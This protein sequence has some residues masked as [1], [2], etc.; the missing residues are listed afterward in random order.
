MYPEVVDTR[1]VLDQHGDGGLPINITEFGWPTQGLN[2]TGF[3]EVS[4]AQRAQYVAQFT[5]A[6]A[7][8][9]C[10]VV[11]IEPHTWVTAEQS[12]FSPE[13]WFGFVHP[14]LS[15]SAT[16]TAYS[17]TIG[18]LAPLATPTPYSTS[19]CSQQLGVA[20]G[21]TTQPAPSSPPPL[22]P[23]PPIPLLHLLL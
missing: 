7:R 19:T 5:K 3:T 23:L 4:D 13:D 17:S 11:R 2:S 16:E 14:N 20:A 10:G 12:I 6:V 8:S 18:Q 1:S 21:T 9:N 22:I 15:R